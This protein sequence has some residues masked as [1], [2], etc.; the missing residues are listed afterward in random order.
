MLKREKQPNKGRFDISGRMM[1]SYEFFSLT[2]SPRKCSLITM[3]SHS[4]HVA[5]ALFEEHVETVSASHPHSS[6]HCDPFR[7]LS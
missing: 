5:A 6:L 3:A 2:L 7:I 4:M 1:E